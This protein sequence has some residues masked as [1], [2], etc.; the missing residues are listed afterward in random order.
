MIL[1][2]IDLGDYHYINHTVP[3]LHHLPFAASFD[4]TDDG[5]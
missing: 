5:A 3:L 4:I 1:S 2:W